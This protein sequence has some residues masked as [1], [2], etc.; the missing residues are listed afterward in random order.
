MIRIKNNLTKDIL[1]II[2]Q[3]PELDIIILNTSNYLILNIKDF[4]EV[5]SSFLY[6]PSFKPATIIP[7]SANVTTEIPLH[8][9]MLKKYTQHIPLTKGSL[10]IFHL[11]T[12][13][14]VHNLTKYY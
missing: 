10:S 4:N 1:S 5:V 13:L 8:S 6:I 14:R 11:V 9:D 2:L 7:P 12:L 3:V